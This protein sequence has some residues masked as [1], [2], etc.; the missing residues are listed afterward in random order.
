MG[1]TTAIMLAIQLLE[2]APGLI[3]TGRRAYEVAQE[4]WEE[5]TSSEAPSDEERSRYAAA[6]ERSHA[7]FQ[8]SATRVDPD[9]PDVP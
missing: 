3:K 5:A 6:L 1:A 4:I 9:D 8:A 7:E 2:M